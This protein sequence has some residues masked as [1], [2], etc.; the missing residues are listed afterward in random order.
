MKQMAIVFLAIMG[1]SL[2]ALATSNDPQNFFS[3]IHPI[4]NYGDLQLVVRRVGNYHAAQITLA[5]VSE[6]VPAVREIHSSESA[7]RNKFA[8]ELGQ[9]LSIPWNEI[10]QVVVFDASTE[11]AVAVGVNYLADQSRIIGKGMFI[12]HG[13]PLRCSE[14]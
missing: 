1:I 6:H 14:H 4:P 11:T 3:C 13:G 9:Q 5:G 2:S 7:Q 12:G 10:S 8:R